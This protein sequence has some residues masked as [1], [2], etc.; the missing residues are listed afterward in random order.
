M[1]ASKT[2]KRLTR[3]RTVMANAAADEG[4]PHSEIADALGIRRQAVTQALNKEGGMPAKGQDGPGP[5]PRCNKAPATETL[6]FTSED[7]RKDSKAYCP[8][9]ADEVKQL[10]VLNEYA[11]S[12]GGYVCNSPGCGEVAY[13]EMVY[14]S[15]PMTVATGYFCPDCIN[16]RADQLGTVVKLRRVCFKCREEKPKDEIRRIIYRGKDPP[17]PLWVCNGCASDYEL[18]LVTALRP[19]D[20]YACQNC[21]R[22]GGYDDFTHQAVRSKGQVRMAC[23]CPDC[24]WMLSHMEKVAT[25]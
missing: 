24:D 14:R 8:K 3:L 17:L 11:R 16:E 19:D 20:R 23:L 15:G 25:P 13:E 6:H 21:D 4:F 5:C 1:P 10:G 2:Q 12:K 18:S 7:G 22:E 9:C